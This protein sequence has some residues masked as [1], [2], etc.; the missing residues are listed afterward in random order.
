[1]KFSQPL[2]CA[3][4]CNMPETWSSFQ[5]CYQIQQFH[6]CQTWILAHNALNVSMGYCHH[7]NAL[8]TGPLQENLAI[9][10]IIIYRSWLQSHTCAFR[11]HNI[12]HKPTSGWITFPL[13]ITVNLNFNGTVRNTLGLSIFLSCIKLKHKLNL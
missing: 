10:A 3:C 8:D 4:R 7:Q 2:Q 12:L 9:I 1:M 6:C 13:Y 11:T 5:Q